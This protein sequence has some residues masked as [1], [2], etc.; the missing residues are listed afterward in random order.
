MGGDRADVGRGFETAVGWLRWN[1]CGGMVGRGELGG[2]SFGIVDAIPLDTLQRDPRSFRTE[3]E[4]VI[5]R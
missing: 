2:K 3:G 5:A 1:G 4:I